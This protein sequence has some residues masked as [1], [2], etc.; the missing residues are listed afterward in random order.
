MDIQQCFKI[1][2]I[3]RDASPDEAKQAY[4]DLVNIWHPDRFSRNPR[5]KQ[6]AEE[7]LKEVNIAYET[8]KSF[9]LSKQEMVPELK[10]DPQAETE[11][12][13]KAEYNKVNSEHESKNKAEAIAETGTVIVL[14]LWSH[15][16][17]AVRRF[18]DNQALKSDEDDRLK[19]GEPGQRQSRGNFRGQGRGM[20]MG[21]GKGMGRG[22]GR[23]G[24][25]GR[26]RV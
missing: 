10:E 23:G 22:R 3:D 26:G 6:K 2:E 5:L 9:L 20:G 25:K 16:S 14:N 13:S 18:I 11:A 17:R 21:R 19:P 15:L 24:G 12:K 1:L 4:K 8:L 7:K